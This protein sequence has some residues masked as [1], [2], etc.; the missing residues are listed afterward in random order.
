MVTEFTLTKSGG[1]YRA[2]RH[3][4]KSDSSRLAVT[5]SHG[6]IVASYERLKEYRCVTVHADFYEGVD[7]N[8]RP[9]WRRHYDAPEGFRNLRS[10]FKS[11]VER[12]YG[13]STKGVR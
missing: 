8:G 3:A 7:E 12:R 13:I 4:W 9:V 6:R 2:D 1:E 10:W 5:D 11:E